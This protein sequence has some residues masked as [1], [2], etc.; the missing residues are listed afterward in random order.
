MTDAL[1]IHYAQALAD[2]VFA[3]DADIKPEQAIEQI[4]TASEFLTGNSELHRI[5]MSP[6]VSKPKKSALIGKIADQF[7]FNRLIR[8]FL[9]VLVGHRRTSELPRIVE[10]FELAVDERLGF[11][12]AEIISANELTGEQKRE[13]E[14]SLANKSGK[15]I[16]PVY[17]IDPSI[18]GGVIARVGSKEYDGSLR[19]RLDAMRRRLAAAS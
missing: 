4:R 18:I 8:N 11:E 12:R 2:A 5:L 13:I 1:A 16:R 7:G 15:R 14:E 9:M 10:G 19:G 17:R 3:K 6:A